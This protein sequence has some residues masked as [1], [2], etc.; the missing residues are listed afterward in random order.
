M[1]FVK[2]INSVNDQERTNGSETLNKSG[3]LD[4]ITPILVIILK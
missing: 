1:I 2:N 4:S 3:K